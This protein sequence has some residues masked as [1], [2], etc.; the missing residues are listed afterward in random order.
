[1]SKNLMRPIAIGLGCI[2]ALVTLLWGW[3]SRAAMVPVPQSAVDEV[4][5]ATAPAPPRLVTEILNSEPIAVLYMTRADDE[6]LV[7]CYPGYVPVVSYRAMGS[8]PD[9]DTG[10]QEGVLRCVMPSRLPQIEPA[11][12]S[13]ESDALPNME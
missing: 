9:A 13:P 7:R 5:V 10:P 2:A 8:N 11:P 1:M 3:H 6:V 12:S 4:V